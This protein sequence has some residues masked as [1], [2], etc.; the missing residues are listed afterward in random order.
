MSSKD[1]DR[2]GHDMKKHYTH[3]GVI[4]C[5]ECR[6]TCFVIEKLKKKK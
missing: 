1:C 2:C 3:N 6:A 4:K 5:I